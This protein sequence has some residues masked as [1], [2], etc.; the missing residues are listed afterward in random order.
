[1]T[2]IALPHTDPVQSHTRTHA[3]T[4][5]GGVLLPRRRIRVNVHL[6]LRRRTG[7][8][9]VREEKQEQWELVDLFVAAGVSEL[10]PP[11]PESN[12]GTRVKVPFPR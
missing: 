4:L 9:A 1:M 6:F 8:L 2:A 11:G 12:Q 10:S 7:T 3:H 5:G